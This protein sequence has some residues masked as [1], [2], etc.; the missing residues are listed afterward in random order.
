MLI[1][2]GAV[3][4]E[5]VDAEVLVEV[6][7]VVLL[8]PAVEHEVY[9]GLEGTPGVVGQYGKLNGVAVG[10]GGT[11]DDLAQGRVLGPGAVDVFEVIGPVV[12]GVVA[13]TGERVA[14]VGACGAVLGG[15]GFPRAVLVRLIALFPG[16]EVDER[17]GEDPVEDV[18]AI[19]A[20]V[21]NG[22]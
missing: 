22:G 18:V 8:H 17:I 12:A 6:F 1:G 15:E 4:G 20:A 21:H 5:L 2:G 3:T 7:E 10:I 16:D 14:A 9:D 11:H 19:D 13:L